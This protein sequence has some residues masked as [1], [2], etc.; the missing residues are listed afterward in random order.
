MVI[1]Q[2]LHDLNQL[3]ALEALLDTQSV[4]EAARRLGLSQPA[5]S[6][7]LAR[8]RERFED[9]LL[10]RAGGGLVL[11]ARAAAMAEPLR[12]ALRALDQAVAVSE[13]D[14]V[15]SKRMFHLDTVDY[16]ELVL[17]PPL[18]SRVR[19]TAPGVD[20]WL[21]REGLAPPRLASGELDLGIG[22]L[23]AE[24]SVAGLRSRAL[25]RERFVVLTRRGHPL[26]EAGLTPRGY[27]DAP[28]AL[29]AP[30]GRLGGVVD[31][32]LEKH[33]LR[34]RIA[35]VVPHFLAAPYAL[36]DS[37]LV[38]TLPERVA[39]AVTTHLPLVVCDPPVDIPG[40]T[41][42]MVWHERVDADP[43][44]RWLRALLV[45]IAEGEASA[46]PVGQEVPVG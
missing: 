45:E 18:L 26:L 37:D 28:H 8:L 41:M 16:G 5:M 20:L 35:L 32:I 10:V 22:V 2:D 31:T 19:A 39:R 23:R 15:R 7:A 14:P 43:S 6:H 30:R 4:T 9:P 3:R 11:T 33:G 29:I 21:H 27:A 24:D 12:R 1:M 17:L 46:C 38:L 13:W 36:L 44:H 42:S 34:R 25:F 40:F